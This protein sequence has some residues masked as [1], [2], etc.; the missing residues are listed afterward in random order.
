VVS[1]VAEE[2]SA[3]DFYYVDVDQAGEIASQFEIRSIPTMVVIKNGEETNRAVG[4]MSEDQ[5]K[6]FAKS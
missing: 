2:E 6:T 5:V 1:K 3:V 4:F